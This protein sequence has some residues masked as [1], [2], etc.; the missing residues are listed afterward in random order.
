MSFQEALEARLS[1]MNVSRTQV[2]AFL[3]DHPPRLSKGAA[4]ICHRFSAWQEP[5]F[6]FRTSK[7]SGAAIFAHMQL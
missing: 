3:R 6:V 1:L 2:A 4:A 5:K 7:T